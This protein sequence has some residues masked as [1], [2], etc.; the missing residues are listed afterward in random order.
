MS[1]QN[2]PAEILLRIFYFINDLETLNQVELVCKLW[3]PHA[4]KTM[5]GCSIFIGKKRTA[6]SFYEYLNKYKELRGSLRNLSINCCMD[7]TIDNR[8]ND[9]NETACKKLLPLIFNKKLERLAGD[10]DDAESY[11]Q[12][13]T[14]IQENPGAKFALRRIPLPVELESSGYQKV[15]LHLQD[16]LEELCLMIFDQESDSEK[17]FLNE[18]KFFT[19][20]KELSITMNRSDV[21]A[22]NLAVNNCP[23]LQVLDVSC[24]AFTT[25]EMTTEQVLNQFPQD[26]NTN[27]FTL[28]YLTIENCIYPSIVEYLALKYSIRKALI[29]IADYEIVLQGTHAIP[30]SAIVE[31]VTDALR[32]VPEYTL[33]IHTEQN[34]PLEAIIAQAQIRTG[35]TSLEAT[36][37]QEEFQTDG[38]IQQHDN[39]IYVNMIYQN[40]S[41]V[42]TLNDVRQNHDDLV[43]IIVTYGSLQREAVL[44]KTF[45]TSDA[46]NILEDEIIRLQNSFADIA[47]KVLNPN[48]V[49]IKCFE[50]RT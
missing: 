18:I 39:V 23:F 50:N 25:A 30:K 3:K 8:F 5:L 12:M 21:N 41:L 22:L 44:T 9:L 27:E 1:I 38:D 49:E 36:V 28:E 26:R 17:K 20:L 7:E 33:V 45:D 6:W 43:R 42:T 37:T 48:L 2:L 15:A 47:V 14:I 11:E 31:R 29:N 40:G 46:D 35:V 34:N 13:L 32:M 16:T 4:I 19:N 10:Y 24:S